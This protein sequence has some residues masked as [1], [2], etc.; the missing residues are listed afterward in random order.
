MRYKKSFKK[1]FKKK[2]RVK[3]NR[4]YRMSRGG[5]RL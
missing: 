5:V 1:K 3:K 2:G 4:S